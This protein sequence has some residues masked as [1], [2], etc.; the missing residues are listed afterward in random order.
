MIRTSVVFW[1]ASFILIGWTGDARAQHGYR[2]HGHVTRGGHYGGSVYVQYAKPRSGHI[3]VGAYP[4]YAD[5]SVGYVA[6][7]NPRFAYANN[8]VSSRPVIVQNY[9]HHR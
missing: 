4:Q 9:H 8:C 2:G 3:A 6:Y 5:P 7:G 1:V